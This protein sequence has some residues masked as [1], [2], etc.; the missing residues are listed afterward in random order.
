M[1]VFSPAYAEE[2]AQGDQALD[3]AANDPTASLMN[4][5]VQDVYTCGYHNLKGE[6]GNA[7]PSP[8][9]DFLSNQYIYAYLRQLSSK[10]R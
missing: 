10:Y 5:Q 7:T 9:S 8:I 4:V 1:M 3:Q 2:P 6:S